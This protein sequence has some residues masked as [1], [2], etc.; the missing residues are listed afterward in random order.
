VNILLILDHSIAEYD[1]LR[2]LTELGYDVFSIGAYT[3][4]HEPG[5][6]LRPPLPKAWHHPELEALVPDQL[7]AKAWLPV[8][9]I[10]WAD[11]IIVHHYLDDRV[12]AQWP[13]IRHKRVIWR[14]CGQ[15]DA[16]LEK[17]M[18]P[19]RSDGL[20]IVRYSPAE[21]RY[22]EPRTWAGQDAL[23]RF[24]KYHADYRPWNGFERRVANVTQ[25][26]RQRGD[27]C[28]LTFW[29]QAT[30]GLRA[31]PAGKGSEQ[32]PG[33]LGKLDYPAMLEYLA[34]SRAYLYTG[35]IPASYTLGLIEAMLI[36]VPIVSIGPD[37]WMGPGELLEAHELVGL[38]DDDPG[39][40]KVKLRELLSDGAYAAAIG[41]AQRRVAL[42]AFDVAKVGQQWRAFLG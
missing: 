37:A 23:I 22:F 40:A 10:E 16:R 32:L 38:W 4:P 13:R 24:G 12:V 19:L 8:D 17:V 36:G 7:H 11:T 28:G 9:L 26:M 14:T 2:M 29:L 39:Q 20:Q 25:D 34:S 5:D 21:Q 15:S 42:E 31:E 33:G 3:R 27:W 1:D 35:T 41:D 30:D 18:G 6:D